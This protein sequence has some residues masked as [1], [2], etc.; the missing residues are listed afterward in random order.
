M[1]ALYILFSKDNYPDIM[2]PAINNSFFYLFYFIPF[3]VINTLLFVPIP[4]AV[5]FDAFRSYRSKL[6]I[7]ERIKEREALVA[8]F[9]SLDIDGN[10]SISKDEFLSLCR[11][12]YNNQF[13]EEK[14]D[15]I[16]EFLDE[17][18]ANNLKLEDF[19]FIVEIM[20]DTKKSEKTIH[21]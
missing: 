9:L 5:I 18:S 2:L 16:F 3:M 7:S 10:G 20:E 17:K 8:C 1:N 15:E 19:F 21:S 12:A 14:V 6:V 4:I 11:V 13:N